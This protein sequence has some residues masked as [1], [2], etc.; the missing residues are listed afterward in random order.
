MAAVTDSE[1]ERR[2]RA[3][4]PGELTLFGSSSPTARVQRMGGVIASVSPATP[5]RSLFNSVYADDSDEIEPVL[6]QLEATY[7]EAG[8]EAWT[9]WI[10]AGHRLGSEV[11]AARGHVLDGAPRSMGLEIAAFR[12]PE[13]ELPRGVEV[14][15]AD[16]VE[17][18]PVNDAAYGLDRV[19][20]TALAGEAA[21]DVRWVAAVEDG[22]PIAC[23]GGIDGG[24][25][26]CITGV[27]TLP[28][29]K[30]RGL[31]SL[32]IARLVADAEE[33]GLRTATLQASRAGAPVY[34][35]LGFRDVGNT[36]MWEKRAGAAESGAMPHH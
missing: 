10:P 11:L 1:L 18:G 5:D 21:V 28:D 17:T 9:V 22:R 31:A 25:D 23:A 26:V 30:G 14:R 34:A 27:A 8:V 20:E 13:R 7:E 24:D 33:R 15:S 19:W 36:E 16:M 6:G 29:H 12:P 35:K 32:L 4:L 2:V 3:G